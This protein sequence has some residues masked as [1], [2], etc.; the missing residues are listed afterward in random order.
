MV[1]V[2]QAINSAERFIAHC[3]PSSIKNNNS[4]IDKAIQKYGANNFWFEI[5]ESQIENYNEREKYWIKE[6]NA[7]SP[8]GYNIQLGGE[9]PPI[10]YGIDHPLSTFDNIEEWDTAYND[11]RK[12]NPPFNTKEILDYYLA[13]KDTPTESAI[14]E[15]VTFSDYMLDKNSVLHLTS[16][17]LKDYNTT[18]ST[19]FI[20]P[21]DEYFLVEL[22]VDDGQ[23]L[24]QCPHCQTQYGYDEDDI[25]ATFD[26]L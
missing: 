1:Y 19:T 15:S 6:L 3:K 14:K 5:I 20:C 4:I 23:H 13:T 22:S 11:G 24:L 7:L 16:D 12:P 8:N 21:K 10:H 18:T 9:D 17:L 2:G 25:E 26:I